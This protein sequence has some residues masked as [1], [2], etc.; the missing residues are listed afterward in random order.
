MLTLYGFSNLSPNSKAILQDLDLKLSVGP[1]ELIAEPQGS[2]AGFSLR[3]I[4]N[5][6]G[7]HRGFHA[8]LPSKR[9][10]L[11]ELGFDCFNA[12]V[13]RPFFLFRWEESFSND[14]IKLSR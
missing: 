13:H 5:F 11:Q 8:P 14:S 2:E 1:K 9:N 7:S 12:S 3:Y 6:N 4:F 10:S